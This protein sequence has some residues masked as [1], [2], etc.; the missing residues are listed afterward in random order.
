MICCGG[1]EN[2]VFKIR[3]YFMTIFSRLQK[4]FSYQCLMSLK[5]IVLIFPR[6]QCD[7]LFTL[8]QLSAWPNG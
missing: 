4:R 1:V 3:C 8:V 7:K 5:T 6:M 2:G